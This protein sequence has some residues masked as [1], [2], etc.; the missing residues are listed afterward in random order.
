V[1]ENTFAAHA[2]P[3]LRRHPPNIRHTNYCNHYT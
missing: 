1:V 3:P 2:P